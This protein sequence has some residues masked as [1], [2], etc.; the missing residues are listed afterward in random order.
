MSSFNS[1][2]HALIICMLLLIVN[3]IFLPG[4]QQGSQ[5]GLRV[6]SD[7]GGRLRP[8]QVHAGQLHVPHRHLLRGGYHPFTFIVI[9]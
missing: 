6:L 7:G 9:R 8:R 3:N 2:V 4:L 1:S 5:E